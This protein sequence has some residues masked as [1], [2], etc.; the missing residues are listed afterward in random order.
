MAVQRKGRTIAREERAWDLNIQ[1]LSYR[2]IAE[3]LNKEG[4]GPISPQAV[5]HAITRV[6]V[7]LRPV[8]LAKAEEQV[9]KQVA[10]LNNAYGEAM[11]A[12]QR[13]KLPALENRKK[14]HVSEPADQAS[15]DAKSR[16][17]YDPTD[18]TLTVTKHRDGDPQYLRTA[19]EALRDVRKLLGL[20][21]PVKTELSGTV[22]GD[23]KG[24]IVIYLPDNGRDEPTAE[25]PD[26]VQSADTAEEDE[27]DSASG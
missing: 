13:S 11:Q 5:G 4:L 10:C 20:D 19:L 8:L 15:A 27:D 17:P 23:G 6:A 3:V 2:L 25:V 12:W 21:A 1:G 9:T 7:R 14:V 22:G 24:D 18:W 26:E 16:G